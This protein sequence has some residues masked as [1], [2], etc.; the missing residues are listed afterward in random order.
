MEPDSSRESAAPLLKEP[1]FARR[2]AEVDGRGGGVDF[3]LAARALE[4]MPV[5][6]GE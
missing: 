2:E 5:G 1:G 4:G 3:D 6:A